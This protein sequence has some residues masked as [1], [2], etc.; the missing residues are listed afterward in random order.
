[1][2]VAVF[3]GPFLAVLVT[4][5][6]RLKKEKRNRQ[7]H[8]FRTL[9]STRAST[10]SPTHVEALNLIDIEFDSK[11]R[12]E[13]QIVESWKL[14]HAH[15]GDSS[16]PPDSWPHRRAELLVDL[17]H[18]MASFL[19]YQFDKA[20]IKNS[21]Y[22]P[23][24]YG[25][26]EVE[27]HALRK[28]VLKVFEGKGAIHVISHMAPDQFDRLTTAGQRNQDGEPDARS[29]AVSAQPDREEQRGLPT[30]PPRG[31]A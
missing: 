31:S 14:Y 24:G 9:M 10:L 30:P 20:H 27:Q 23:K 11:S 3:S 2:I 8:V 13:R 15:L 6:S 26:V 25:E 7:I 21:S 29:N 19:G 16:Y 5:R 22:Y 4:E 18:E 12:P 17:L 1:M 28:S